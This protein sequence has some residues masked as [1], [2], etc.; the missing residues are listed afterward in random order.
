MVRPLTLSDSINSS[1]GDWGSD[2]YVYIETDS[3][4]GRIRATG[5]AI[6]PVYTMSDKRPTRSARNGPTCCPGAEA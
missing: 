1:G 4:L 6:E 3:G 2:G 5:G